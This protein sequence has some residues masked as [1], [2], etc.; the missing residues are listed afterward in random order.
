MISNTFVADQGLQ[1]TIF[2]FPL[3]NDYSLVS[4]VVS[5]G[6]IIAKE[7]SAT[8]SMKSRELPEFMEKL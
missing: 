2:R 4:C 1:P 3:V 8:E 6:Q 5:L 7:E